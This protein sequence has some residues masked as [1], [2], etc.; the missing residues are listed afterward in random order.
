MCG[1]CTSRPQPLHRSCLCLLAL[2]LT[3]ALTPAWEMASR[4]SHYC[5][6]RR[7]ADLMDLS[8]DRSRLDF[9]LRP[10]ATAPPAPAREGS[11]PAP[12]NAG[13]GVPQLL[14]MQSMPL[15]EGRG[16]Q[17]ADPIQSPNIPS[18]RPWPAVPECAF[19]HSDA[20]PPCEGRPAVRATEAEARVRVGGC[21]SAPAG[22][23]EEANERGQLE[24]SPDSGGSPDSWA[25]KGEAECR[26]SEQQTWG[27]QPVAEGRRSEPESRRFPSGAEGRQSDL[28]SMPARAAEAVSG[29]ARD[30]LESW[31]SVWG[32]G[33][34]TGRSQPGMERDQDARSPG[35]PEADGCLAADAN[36]ADAAVDLAAV[37]VAEQA[38]LW[39]AVEAR[40]AMQAKA[41]RG[42]GVQRGRGSDANPKNPR[43]AAKCAA[44]QAE[45]ASACSGDQNSWKTPDGAAAQPRKR[46]EAGVAMSGGSSKRRQLTLASFFL[47]GA[48]R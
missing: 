34:R 30:P 13:G 36:R 37:D 4:G 14:H 12:P 20:A 35:R 17:S 44:A 27:A 45:Q 6:V 33:P 43:L 40:N 18:T 42:G 19:V 26:G 8:K 7:F 2:A 21:G 24:W 11:C 23:C 41:R 5:W 32:S 3:L 16:R 47:A 9:F 28:R 46:T 25:S 22:P 15:P 48:Q 39:A 38:R 29:D 31:D 10:A 1:P